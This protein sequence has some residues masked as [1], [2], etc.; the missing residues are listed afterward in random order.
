MKGLTKDKASQSMSQSTSRTCLQSLQNKSELLV[1]NMN[2]TN[3][4]LKTTPIITIVKGSKPINA[5]TTAASGCAS[6]ELDFTSHT[7][8][9]G[10]GLTAS[11]L[12]RRQLDP[13]KSLIS[14]QNLLQNKVLTGN[15]NSSTS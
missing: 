1:N 11:Q 15:Q 14:I 13:S 2:S 9:H 12:S 3:V 7:K 6:V 8:R 5:R 4:S 10:G